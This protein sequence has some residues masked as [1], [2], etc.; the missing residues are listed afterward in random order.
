MGEYA[1]VRSR[2][3]RLEAMKEEGDKRAPLVLQ[4]ID[5]ISDY[6]SA[7]QVGITFTSIG[8]G[9]VGE[10]V[11]AHA[12][13][14]SLGGP[15]SHGVAVVVSVVIAYLI[16]T[17]AHIVAGELVP[18][19]YVIQHAEGVARRIS[20]PF[21][22]SR[23]LFSPII[24]VLTGVS[25]WILRR[26]GVDPHAVDEEGGTP[27]ELKAIIAESYSGGEMEPGQSALPTGGFPLQP[28]EA[29]QGMTPTPPRVT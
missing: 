9:A 14:G 4:Q 12:L 20:R 29:R 7:S 2:R 21:R 22:T 25:H 3:S 11:V 15:L 26:L 28:Q 24:V 16:I 27:E 13:E 19:L 23:R 8:I 5:E 17:S 18:K 6:I 1:L 10:P